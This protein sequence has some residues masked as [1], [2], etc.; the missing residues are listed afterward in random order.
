MRA[1]DGLKPKLKAQRE[2]AEA[3]V[4][5]LEIGWSRNDL[6]ALEKIWWSIHNSDGKLRQAK[7]DPHV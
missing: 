6:D 2:C 4:K 7:G 1:A 5:M 3:M